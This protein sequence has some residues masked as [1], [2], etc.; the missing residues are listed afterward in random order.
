MFVLVVGVG[1]ACLR[2]VEED[3]VLGLGVGAY[4]GSSAG[5]GYHLVSVEAEHAVAPEGAE[6]SSVEGA[7]EALGG[8]LYHGYAVAVGDL[9]YA[10][11]PVWHA[12]ERHGYYGLW[13]AAGDGHAVVDG[14]LEEVGVDV[15]RVRLGVDE[16]GRGPEVCHRVARGAE[17]EGLH[18]HLVA[19]ADAACQQSQVDGCRTG[20]KACHGLVERGGAVFAAVDECRQ[21]VLEGV[22]VR[23][24]RHDPVRVES[25][26]YEIHL[27]AAH[28]RQAEVNPLVHYLRLIGG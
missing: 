23:S 1:L 8:V 24:H 25:L 2:C 17:R 13:L 18:Q 11:D 9:G 26:L 16:D 21:L 15:P 20:A 22:H 12:V 19:G 7:S 5:G 27:P 6:D 10:V 4:E 28:M 14:L 3:A